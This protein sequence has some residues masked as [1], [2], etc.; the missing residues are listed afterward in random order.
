[1]TAVAIATALQYGLP[2]AIKLVEK[3]S[4]EQPE[5]PEPKEWLDL[6]KHP[7]LT[8]NYDQ[9][10]ADAAAKRAATV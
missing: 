10:K 6:L 4:T 5:N 8:R 1:M 9:W 7:S 2:L 3:W